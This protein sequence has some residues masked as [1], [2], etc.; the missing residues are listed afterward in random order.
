MCRLCWDKAGDDNAVADGHMSEAEF[1][2]RYGEHSTWVKRA[3]V[4]VEPTPAPA[5]GP[6]IVELPDELNPI[7]IFAMTST[8]L[9]VDAVAGRINLQELAILQL[10]NRGL[11]Q[12]GEWVGFREAGSEAISAIG[13]LRSPQ[14]VDTSHGPCECDHTF[15]DH[16]H[17]DLSGRVECTEC[18]CDEFEEVAQ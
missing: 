1:F 10:S 2:A 3:E 17:N 14:V 7:G 5:A 12:D 15:T 16:E 4:D 11:N 13:A 8:K 9:L 6:A 18:G